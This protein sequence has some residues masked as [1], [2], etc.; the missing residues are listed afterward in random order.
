MVQPEG[1]TVVKNILSDPHVIAA[2]LCIGECTG[3]A[4]AIP[5]HHGRGDQMR[6]A[7]VSFSR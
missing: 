4:S 1:I 3:N 5:L 2:F 7:Q 6:G